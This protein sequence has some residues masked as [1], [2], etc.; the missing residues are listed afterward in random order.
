MCLP[1]RK[2]LTTTEEESLREDRQAGLSIRALA[3]KYDVSV[4]TAW[5]YCQSVVVPDENK[6]EAQRLIDQGIATLMGIVEARRDEA[7]ERA[8]ERFLELMGRNLRVSPRNLGM[9][10]GQRPDATLVR[11]KKQWEKADNPVREGENGIRILAPCFVPL[12]PDG[13]EPGPDEAP[14]GKRVLRRF[15]PVQV[16]DV[17]QTEQGECRRDPD[18]EAILLRMMAVADARGIEVKDKSWQ[19]KYTPLLGKSLGGTIHL[20]DGLDTIPRLQVLAHE[21]AHEELHHGGYRPS[22]HIREREAEA[23]AFLVCSALGIPTNALGGGAYLLRH[24]ATPRNLLK[25]LDC[26]RKC[27][28]GILDAVSTHQ[29]ES[30]RTITSNR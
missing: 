19:G 17:A 5:R 6:D 26:I 22:Y 7:N 29:S 20:V 4:R 11:S 3:G 27:A 10:Y 12:K 30:V 9:V 18:A 14:D 15:V 28:L 13:E 24:K 2:K 8:R 23:V 21:L 1:S 16:F 25:S